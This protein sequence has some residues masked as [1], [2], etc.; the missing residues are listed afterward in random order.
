MSELRDIS[1]LSP[2]DFRADVR[3]SSVQLELRNSNSQSEKRA[4]KSQPGMLTDLWQH[5][6]ASKLDSV[7]LTGKSVSSLA[8]KNATQPK[9]D[10]S[11]CDSDNLASHCDTLPATKVDTNS[12]KDIVKIN[13]RFISSVHIEKGIR[14]SPRALNLSK[15]Q[16]LSQQPPLSAGDPI[17]HLT[18]MD[19]S[20]PMAART[21]A[22]SGEPSKM[23]RS[24]AMFNIKAAATDAETTS[25]A[26]GKAVVN[27]DS[28]P[29]YSSHVEVL[30]PKSVSSGHLLAKEDKRSNVYLTDSEYGE[31]RLLGL[32]EEEADFKPQGAY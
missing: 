24:T 13:P 3:T 6:S 20:P 11:H 2:R 16:R 19:T 8:E 26:A 30:T 7:A 14:L 1:S 27:A 9:F 10:Q 21:P 5:Q 17:N 32:S 12:P 31:D 25:A 29:T 23:R 28:T 4:T 18:D 15:Q 22:A